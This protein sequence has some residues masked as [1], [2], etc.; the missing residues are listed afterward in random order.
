MFVDVQAFNFLSFI[1]T[2][3]HGALERK[4]DQPGSG[5]TEKT[6]ASNTNQL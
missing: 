5:E 2:D 1:D 3:A 6:T 4:K